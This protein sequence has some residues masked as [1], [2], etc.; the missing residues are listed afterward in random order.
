M[1][2][3]RILAARHGVRGEHAAPADHRAAQDARLTPSQQPGPTAPASYD[4]LVLDRHLEVVDH[5]VEVTDV[6]PVRDQRGG[7]DLEVQVAVHRVV[8]AHTTLSP[9]RRVPSCARSRV[10]SPMCTQRR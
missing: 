8:A 3:S 9:M 2:R 10:R 6:D 1:T 5:V 4:A 7:A